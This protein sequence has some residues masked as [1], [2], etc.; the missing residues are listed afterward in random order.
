MKFSHFVSCILH[1]FSDQRYFSGV[2]SAVLLGFLTFV[3]L[4]GLFVPVGLE[5]AKVAL[6]ILSINAGLVGM[7]LGVLMPT[8][9]P[10]VCLGVNVALFVGCFLGVQNSLFLPVVGGVAALVGVFL[11]TRYDRLKVFKDYLAVHKCRILT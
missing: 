10:G 3:F 8:V 11:S 7:S 9:L 4:E 6:W 1:I 5:L 2:L